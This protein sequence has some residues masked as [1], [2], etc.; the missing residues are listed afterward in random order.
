MEK[1]TVTSEKIHFSR[2]SRATDA[3]I[4]A[5]AED[6]RDNGLKN[7]ILVDAHSGL[8]LDGLNRFLA[9]RMLGWSV[10]PASFFET[11][12]EAAD[13]LQTQRKGKIFDYRRVME[14]YQDFRTLS[15]E[16]DTRRRTG[17]R[18]L[19][20][21]PL[22]PME[23]ARLVCGRACGVSENAINRLNVL[24]RLANNG[25]TEAQEIVTQIFDSPPGSPIVGYERI[26]NMSAAERRGFPM[27]EEKRVQ[28]LVNVVKAAETAVDQAFR[29]GGLHTLS[30][31]GRQAVQEKVNNLTR[32]IR[33]LSRELRGK[34]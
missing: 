12:A 23:G 19:K 33:V 24:T 27:E 21:V 4:K 20:G 30:P 1:G 11:P 22:P 25:N 26:M 31:E 13:I 17:A 34:F 2:Q 29:I 7:P 32:A 10:V 9:Y 3:E 8:L 16:W 6:I 14:F 18:R 5:L 28:A 15:R